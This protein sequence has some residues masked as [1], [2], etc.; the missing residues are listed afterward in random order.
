MDKKKMIQI[1]IAVV[2]FAIVIWQAMDMFGGGGG[3]GGGGEVKRETRPN[4]DIPKRAPLPEKLTKNAV[5]ENA[6]STEREAQLM[7][8]QQETQ[9]KYVDAL[10][11][12][13]MLKINA[14]IAATT[15]NIA[16]SKEDVVTSQVKML[17]LL[18]E[19]NPKPIA[20]PVQ[21]VNTQLPPQGL[22]PSEPPP[23]PAP[24]IGDSYSVVTVTKIRGH[25]TAVITGA[26]NLYSVSV[27]DVL[28][29]DGS[30]VKSINRTGVVLEKGNVTKTLSMNAII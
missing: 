8:M 6:G 14:E 30:T 25:W 17:E 18:K 1:A 10:N 26:N 20:A 2:I 9:V 12:L 16:K 27:G 4:P 13:Q 23:P 22:R 29:D 24:V 5:K 7:R 28:A 11:E 21:V 19:A 3:G 15:K